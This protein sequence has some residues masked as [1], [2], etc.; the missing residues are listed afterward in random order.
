VAALLVLGRAWFV[1]G[2]PGAP[3]PPLG[4][5]GPWAKAVAGVLARAGITGFLGNLEE[6]YD[7]A[8]ES[9]GQWEAFLQALVD[10]YGRDQEFIIKQV[11]ERL[12]T[13]EKLRAL[14]PDELDV[15]QPKGLARR[16]GNAFKK[17]GSSSK[18]VISPRRAA[19]AEHSSGRSRR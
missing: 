4:N 2:R 8:D 12:K 18:S 6:L 16:I 3:A 1:A 7:Q 13:D 11:E 14:A 19:G 10:E 5:F 15:D 17:I 9:A